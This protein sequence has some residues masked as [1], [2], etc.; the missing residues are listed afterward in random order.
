M[1]IRTANDGRLDS[2]AWLCVNALPANPII[3]PAHPS[4]RL[5]CLEG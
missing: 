2:K 3:S 1:Q 5:L 4:P